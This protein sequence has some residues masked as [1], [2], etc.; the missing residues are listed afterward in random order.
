MGPW[1][2]RIGA[3]NTDVEAFG[4]FLREINAGRSLDCLPQG[5]Y[6]AKMIGNDF[7]RFIEESAS[8]RAKRIARFMD[9]V[10]LFDDNVKSLQAD[11]A[12]VQRLLGLKGLSVNG[13][14]TEQGG[15][16]KT[17]EANDHITELKKRLLTR[18]RNIIVSHYDFDFNTDEDEDDEDDA[19]APLAEDEIEFI[20]SL[21]N[22]GK[23]SEEDAELILVVMRN[24]VDRIEEHLGLFAKGFPHLAKNFCSL[25]VDAEDKEA[26]AKLVLD[27]INEGD[28][29]GEYQLFWF[30]TMLENYLIKTRA[31][32][33]IIDALYRPLHPGKRA[34]DVQAFPRRMPHCCRSRSDAVW[35]RMAREMPGRRHGVLHFV[36]STWPLLPLLISC[37]VW[38][39]SNQHRRPFSYTLRGP[40]LRIPNSNT[41]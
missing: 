21:L 28:H 12:E 27:V 6:P 23:L 30:G 33:D 36:R 8:I 35:D 13:A 5:L 11:F 40:F 32:P 38:L 29:V 22:A 18:R 25:C 26:V 19:T 2:E 31:A 24:N 1:F 17:D 14:K 4:K 3:S 16:S 10:Y 20:L 34:I 39:F 9:D 15:I 37:R 7:L 41:T